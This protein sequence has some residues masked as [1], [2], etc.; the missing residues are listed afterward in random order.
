MSTDDVMIG[1]EARNEASNCQNRTNHDLYL[2]AIHSPP[3][4]VSEMREWSRACR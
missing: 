1:Y 2:W 4:D 3:G